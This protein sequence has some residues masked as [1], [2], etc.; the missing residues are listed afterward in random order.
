PVTGN[1]VADAKGSA[2]SKERVLGTVTKLATTV[3]NALGDKTS[4]SAQ[5]FAMKTISATS[6]DVVGQYAAG[7]ELQSKAK[8]E[9][10]RQAF[11]K[12]VELDPKF[13][14]GYQS[15]AAMSRNVGR[16]E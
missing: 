6:L 10:A 13:G 9:D 3:R 15:L 1:V 4:E 11:L 12:A 8:Y 16:P 5:L 14:L 2:S 7:V